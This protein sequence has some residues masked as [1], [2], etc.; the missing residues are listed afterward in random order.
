MAR[1]YSSKGGFN[2]PPRYSADHSTSPLDD[3]RAL[4]AQAV[5]ALV[6][7]WRERGRRMVFAAMLSL[8]HRLRQ[9]LTY[10]RLV[11]FPHLLVAAWVVVL[12]WGERWVF[13]SKVESCHWSSWENWVRQ[14]S[15]VRRG[16]MTR[17][18]ANT[19]FSLPAQHPTASPSSP[20][21]SSPT[22]TRTRAARGRSTP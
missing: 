1:P 20:T 10:N 11:S 4:V 22:L 18:D 15:A 2:H 5:R 12:L 13:H 6:R 17:R 19:V 21:P 8:A 3:L 16:E 7:F 14:T 9:N